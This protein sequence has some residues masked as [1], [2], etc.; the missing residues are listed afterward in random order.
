M[1][2]GGTLHVLAL[3]FGQQR[4]R[5]A[6][7]LL[8]PRLLR[9]DPGL[10]RG[11]PV[12]NRHELVLGR[13]VFGSPRGA[14]LAQTV[15]AALRQSGPVASVAEPVPKAGAG[16]GL[17]VLRN[18]RSPVGLASMI[19]AGAGSHGFFGRYLARHI[20]KAQF[21]ELDGA[22]HWAFAGDQ[23]PILARIRQFIASL[24]A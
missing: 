4:H 2:F 16:E 18:V 9:I 1:V 7:Q 8:P 22:D 15:C 14:H 6:G 13:A 21:V 12:E 3:V 19:R 11:A 10:S 5:P 20:T 23:Q 17:P 24:A